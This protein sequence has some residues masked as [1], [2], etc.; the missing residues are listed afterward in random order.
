M[1][2]T[3]RD[4]KLSFGL[5]KA[6]YFDHCFLYIFLCDLFQFSNDLD[7][8]KYADD[9]TPQSTNTNLNKVLH[10]LE[11]MSKILFKWFTGDLLKP[12]PGPSH[13]DMQILKI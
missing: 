13:Q 10:N 7:V 12:N 4:L 5:H 1:T 2:R 6:L 11:K 9:N 8:T 3:V